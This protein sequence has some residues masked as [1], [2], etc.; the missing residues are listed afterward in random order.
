MRPRTVQS[1][2]KTRVEVVATSYLIDGKEAQEEDYARAIDSLE[3]AARGFVHVKIPEK[4][5]LTVS[6]DP[7]GFVVTEQRRDGSSWT[8]PTLPIERAKNL[9]GSFLSGRDDW[10]EGLEWNQTKL[11]DREALR[12]SRRIVLVTAIF[13]AL[14]AWLAAF[15]RK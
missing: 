8:G 5:T 10:R 12:R 9:V 1:L 6:T 15:L 14:A 11:T 4:G 2:F 3:S 13:L 7:C